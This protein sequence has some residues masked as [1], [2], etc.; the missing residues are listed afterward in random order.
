[1]KQ[2]YKDTQ[3]FLDDVHN[4]LSIKKVA[5]DMGILSEN[6]FKKEFFTN[7]IFHDGDKTP[8]L[9][10]KENFW[11]C[12]GCGAKGDLV[13][14]IQLYYNTDFIEAVKKLADYFEINIEN[15]KYVFDDKVKG[16]KAEWENYLTDMENAAKEIKEYKRDFFPQE[17]GYDKIIDYIVFPIT[18]KSGAILGFTKRRVDHENDEEN[19]RNKWVHSTLKYS[20]ISQCHNIFNLHIASPEMR[21]KHAIIVTEGPKDVIGYQRIGYNNTICVCGTSN[22]SNIW[23]LIL[24][25]KNI[26][27][28]MDSD[29]AGVKA[30]ISTILFLAKIHD[31]K[32]IECVVLPNGEDP[33]SVTEL[34]KY[35][36]ERI[37]AID[38]LV[39]Y[40][41]DEDIKTCYDSIPEY[42]KLYFKK[43]MCFVKN[44]SLVETESYLDFNKAKTEIPEEMSEKDR[45]LAILSCEDKDVPLVEIDKVKRILKLKYGI[46]T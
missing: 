21:K 1:M 40:G 12:Y 41:E 30:S 42:N 27:L 34:Q 22:S 14:F 33:Y 43:R 39:K 17:V 36:D 10:I 2:S 16:L 9:Q 3:T 44:F 4:E 15:M 5:I 26:V 8:S 31:I 24:P 19:K 45:F 13:A 46:K 35:Y 29:K 37:P 11:K 23:D 6:D 18:S 28:S 7:C 38:F 20:L 32:N 25:V